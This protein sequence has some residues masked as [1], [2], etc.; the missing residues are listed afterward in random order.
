[1]IS[2]ERV[3]GQMKVPG[4]GEALVR[5]GVDEGLAY[6]GKRDLPRRG[7]ERLRVSVP[8]ESRRSGRPPLAPGQELRGYVAQRVLRVVMA[9]VVA[10]AAT[11]FLG[12]VR[13]YRGNTRGST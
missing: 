11:V 12:V 8:K 1:M 4:H 7:R 5:S 2:A 13:P 6:Q 9:V 10:T 3:R